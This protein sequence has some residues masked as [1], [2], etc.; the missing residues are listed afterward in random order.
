MLKD[1]IGPKIAKLVKMNYIFL[2]LSADSTKHSFSNEI[3]EPGV[4]WIF[5]EI[6]WE[7]SIL[8]LSK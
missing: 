4:R 1:I 8:R 6:G 2:L 7:S 5:V 3:D